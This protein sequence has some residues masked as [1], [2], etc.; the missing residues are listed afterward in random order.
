MEEKN[1]MSHEEFTE[2]DQSE[3]Q[4]HLQK[5][6]QRRSRGRMSLL[7]LALGV[8]VMLG[9]AGMLTWQIT[10]HQAPSPTPATAGSLGAQQTKAVLQSQQPELPPGPQGNQPVYWQAIQEQVAQGLHLSPVQIQTELQPPVS[11]TKGGTP[12]NIGNVAL[13]QGI[14]LD[15]LRTIEINAMQQAFNK[16][17]SQGVETQQQVDQWMQMV[18]GWAQSNLN[19]YVTDVFVNH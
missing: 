1:R 2:Q 14:S 17:V 12:P 19:G 3:L 4:Q 9:G 8:I 15:Q 11:N 7:L 5:K 13:E 16:L 18:R 6:P 10:A